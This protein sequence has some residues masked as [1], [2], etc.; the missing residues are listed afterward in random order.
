MSAPGV[1]G[2]RVRTSDAERE[3]VV[4]I[5]RAA[6]GEGRLG[7]AEGEER[8]AAAYAAVYRD[9]LVPLTGDLPDG[10]LPG[11]VSTPAV[12]RWAAAH[13]RRLR[14]HAGLVAAAGLVLV[15]L[16]ALSGAHVFWPLLPLLFLGFGLARHA[17]WR[18]WAWRHGYAGRRWADAEGWGTPG[19]GRPGAWAPGGPARPEAGAPGNP[20]RPEAGAPPGR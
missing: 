15:G 8:I 10:D 4:D 12:E 19:W 16:W 7:M 1:P 13:R 11:R 17:A 14:R 3:Q 20:A 18:G 2:R 5:L 6:I 9:E